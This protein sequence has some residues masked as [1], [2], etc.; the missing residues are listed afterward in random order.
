MPVGAEPTHAASIWPKS[1]GASATR[2]RIAWTVNDPPP[3]A[4]ASPTLTRAAVRTGSGRSDRLIGPSIVTGRP[5]VEEAKSS[6]LVR[7]QFQ[8]S[9][10]GS[11][12][13]AASCHEQQGAEE[14]S[15]DE[16][17]GPHVRMEAR[18][19]PPPGVSITNTSPAASSAL[20]V[21]REHRRACRP[22][23][24]PIAARPRRRAPPARPNGGTLRREATITAVIGSRK[25]MRRIAPSP[26][27]HRP[28]PPEPRRIENSSKPHRVAQLQHL[29]VGHARVGHVRLHRRGAV[30][31][32]ARRRRRRRSSRSIAGSRHRTGSCSSSPGC[33]RSRRAL[34]TA[35][36]R[37]PG[38]TSVLPATTAA[39]GCG[40]KE[41]AGRDHDPE[42]LEAAVIERN[43]V[44]DQ[45]AEH[46]QHHGARH[47][48]RRV[49]I[50]SRAAAR[51]R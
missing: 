1:S 43:V 14:T 33:T 3:G 42:R 2:S 30:E 19:P 22:R 45:A 6:R 49:E 36:C 34:R 25:R 41:C 38:E 51:C 21:P 39:P 44:A 10:E 29:R 8:S 28:A 5:S 17:R 12:Q 11:S 9:A 31:I 47:G 15:Q 46:V 4:D 16:A 48:R 24:R 37:W 50:A 18:N 13:T 7:Y 26:P 20:S 40:R 23:A 32:R 35:R 27:R